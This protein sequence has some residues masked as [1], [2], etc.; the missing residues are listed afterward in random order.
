MFV[1]LLLLSVKMTRE[2]MT[3][4][5]MLI[6][7]KLYVLARCVCIVVVF[8]GDDDGD[9]NND[10]DTYKIVHLSEVLSVVVVVCQ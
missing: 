9:N 4:M 6:L 8:I 1:S 5:M 2:V 3:I 10:A 7:T